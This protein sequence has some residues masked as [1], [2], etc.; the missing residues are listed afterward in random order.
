MR[1]LL[2]DGELRGLA[3]ARPHFRKLPREQRA[4][5]RA[6]A[7]A[8]E[9]IAAAPDA[10]AP[11]GVVAV[12]GM[13]ERGVHEIAERDRTGGGDPGAE[14]FREWGGRHLVDD[15]LNHGFPGLRGLRGFFDLIPPL[16]NKVTDAVVAGVSDLGYSLA[17]AVR[18][19]PR[20]GITFQKSE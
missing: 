1:A 18:L 9:E 7:D 8:G 12:R 4:E 11:G 3:E 20:D 19:F 10:G 5:K 13:V 14:D 17:A 2:D 16:G 15:F 6:G